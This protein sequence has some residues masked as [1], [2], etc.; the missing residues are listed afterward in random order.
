MTVFYYLRNNICDFG[1]NEI[2]FHEQFMQKTR[3]L[4]FFLQQYNLLYDYS[5]VGLMFL[6]E[7]L[8]RCFLSCIDIKV[9][10]VK[11]TVKVMPWQQ[12][13]CLGFTPVSK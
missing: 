8:F 1:D 10:I 9:Y 2:T 5:P 6:S 7:R 12:E 4:L 3:K 13:L 11:V